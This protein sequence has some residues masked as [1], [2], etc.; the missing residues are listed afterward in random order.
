MGA[1][2]P[3]AGSV[4]PILTN[5]TAIASSVGAIAKAIDG[6]RAE[7]KLAE[8]QLRAQQD[9]QIRQQ[10][11]DAELAKEQRALEAEQD[12][13][14]RRDALKR[15]VARQRASFGASGISKGTGGSADAVLLGLV[16]ESEEELKRREQLDNIRN[17]ALD[18]GIGQQ[19]S[20]NVLRA[21]QLTEKNNLNR[22][23]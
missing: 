2:A 11:Q 16:D 17:R 23:F 21:T 9:L 14:R 22:L 19:R 6:G 7:D 20:I 13:E 1:L 15:A 5:A 18:Q 4:L 10:Q 12:E 3:A 8:K